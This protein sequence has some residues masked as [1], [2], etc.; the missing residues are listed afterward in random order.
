M[1]NLPTLIK[2]KKIC[3]KLKLQNAFDRESGVSLDSIGEKES[4]ILN[5][6]IKGNYVGKTENGKIYLKQNNKKDSKKLTL[7][8]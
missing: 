3:W 2:M 4:Y 7:K 1:Q 6:L 5:K 8:K